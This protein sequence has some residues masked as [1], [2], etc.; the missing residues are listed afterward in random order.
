MQKGRLKKDDCSPF[1]YKTFS[2]REGPPWQESTLKKRLKIDLIEAYVLFLLFFF[3]P[4][5]HLK[6]PVTFP[7]NLATKILRVPK[8][9][10]MK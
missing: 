4:S 6:Q 1:P 5:L 2:K 8:Q 9:K 10:N 7:T 3:N